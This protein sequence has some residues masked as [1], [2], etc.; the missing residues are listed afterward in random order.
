MP[1]KAKFDLVAKAGEQMT[2]AQS[3]IVAGY[4][5]M[6]VAD[7]TDLRVKLRAQGVVLRVLKNRLAKIAFQQS[8]LPIPDAHLKGPS[9]FI[10]SMKDPVAGPKILTDYLKTNEKMKVKCAIFEKT[11]MD[12]AGVLMLANLPSREQLLGRLLGDLKSPVTRLAIGLKAT[13]SK[14]VYAIKAVADKK[15]KAA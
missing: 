1:S 15:E 13:V 5:G 8:G 2:Q 9:A 14:V 3:I 4:R 7:M 10:F 6:S 12:A 11:I